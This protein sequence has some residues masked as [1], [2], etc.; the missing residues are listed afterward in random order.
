VRAPLKDHV[1]LERV[2]RQLVEDLQLGVGI[3]VSGGGGY[4]NT[5]RTSKIVSRAVRT[6]KR[7]GLK[8]SVVERAG[9]SDSR[10]FSPEGVEAIDF[11]PIGGN[12][13]GPDE[14]VEIW[15]LERARAFYIGVLEEL[16]LED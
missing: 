13:H 6:L 16:L 10:Y 9:A 7:L 5:P 12:I 8:G 1:K 14:Y 15:S 3:K 4:L 2:A 11:G